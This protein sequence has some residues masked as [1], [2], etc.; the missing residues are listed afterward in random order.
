MTALSPAI[1]LKGMFNGFGAYLGLEVLEYGQDCTIIGLQVRPEHLN[2]AGNL[3]GGV[4]ASMADNAM[5]M[6]GTWHADPTQWRL[7]LT[8]S[9]NINY[10]AAAP[11]DSQVRVVARIRGGGPK[12]FMTSCDVLDAQD[13]LLASAEGVFKRGSLRQMPA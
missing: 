7:A 8:L 12:I 3:H 10:I 4:I 9:L 2:Q 11:A 5:G 1:D 13:R 6:S